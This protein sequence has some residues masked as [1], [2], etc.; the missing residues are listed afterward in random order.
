M[1]ACQNSI[2]W[3]G[4]CNSTIGDFQGR[5]LALAPY[6][7]VIDSVKRPIPTRVSDLR[8]RPGKGSSG[9]PLVNLVP[10][11]GVAD[12]RALRRLFYHLQVGS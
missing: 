6:E 12:A 11:I 1:I 5:A 3:L 9:F 2:Y 8:I 10:R 4:E 7:D